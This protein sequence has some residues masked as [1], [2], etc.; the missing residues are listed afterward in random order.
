MTKS[1][2]EPV[3]FAVPSGNFGNIHAGL[4]ARS[5][6]LPIRRLILATNENNVL[7]EF[8]STGRYRV[9]ASSEVVATSS[10]SMDISNA[11]NFERYVFDLVGAMGR[12]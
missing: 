9:R 2:Y 6:G 4:I 5:M 7:D 10:P 11:S 3:A 1:N 12:R 8:F